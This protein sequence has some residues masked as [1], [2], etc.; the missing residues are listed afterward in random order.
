MGNE[1]TKQSKGS[2]VFAFLQKLGR[3]LMLP[4]AILPIAGLLLRLGA[5]DL[6]DLPFMFKAGDAI[7]GNLSLIFAIGVA[8]G[9]AK[10]NHG[11]AALAAFIG[12]QV[13][14]A[15]APEFAQMFWGE[16]GGTDMAV[17]GGILVGLMAGILYNK[18]Y[19]IKLPPYLAFFG[20]RRF[21]P[22]IT[23]L[24]A[25]GLGLLA[26]LI[27]PTIGG[28]FNSFGAWVIESGPLGKFFYGVLNRLLIVT[29]LHHVFNT[30]LWFQFGEF[31]NAAGE[32]VTGDIARFMAGDPT[33]GGFMA[34]F[35]PIMMFGLPAAALAMY[36]TAFP[37]N[38]KRAAG[39]L[40]SAALTAFLTGVTE[41]LEFSFMFLAPVLYG[42]HAVLTGISLALMDVLGIKLGFT[43]S[44]GLFD[45]VLNFGIA[46]KPL[47]ALVIGAGYFA[48][49]FFL[50]RFFILTFNI[51]TIGREDELNSDAI[52][53][54]TP[55]TLG[56]T[57]AAK[58]ITAL[59]GV[60]NIVEIDNCATRLRLKVNDISLV[61]DEVI[62]SLGARGMLKPSAHAVQIIIG[63]EVELL[64]GD[65]K[66]LWKS[67]GGP[68]VSQQ[69]VDFSEDHEVAVLRPTNDDVAMAEH[70]LK[71]LGGTDNVLKA[72][73]AAGTR[74]L[75]TLK[76]EK[77]P[78][79]VELQTVGIQ[80]VQVKGTNVLITIGDRAE[81][82]AQAM[83]DLL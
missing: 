80:T 16:A 51:K 29:G 19:R 4:I 28:W 30:P 74:I 73:V 35:F 22:I 10:E 77:E 82:V 26:A 72:E 49:Y 36:T 55:S 21:V 11:A 41:P 27:W 12:Y 75:A 34:G 3:S 33:A 48:I 20:G 13:M 57:P 40:L 67:A 54:A 45:Y 23:G 5:G 39:I 52:S 18:F 2:E 53:S 68:E 62:T 7:F 38:K 32:V 69:G 31:T 61:Q 56:D 50:F 24:S 64:A 70:C 17:L 43:F 14:I 79:L 81:Y 59:G 66:D 15:S 44:A 60:R 6:L 78:D 71:A 58:Y 47:L 1:L 46:T 83:S 8:V 37:K 76:T 42:I 65:M 25:L 63:P 9:W